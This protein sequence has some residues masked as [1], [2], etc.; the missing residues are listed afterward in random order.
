MPG[1]ESY[2][3]L[4]RADV[5]FTIRT[6]MVD[7][8]EAAHT[9]R[10]ARAKA[11]SEQAEHDTA[12]VRAWLMIRYRGGLDAGVTRRAGHFYGVR[13]HRVSH[14]LMDYPDFC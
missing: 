4:P 14:G 2:S 10:Q 13:A 3:T 11:T 1:V 9:I 7:A 6:E 5:I 12:D 8:H